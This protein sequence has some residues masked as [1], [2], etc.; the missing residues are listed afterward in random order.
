MDPTPAPR[1]SGKV[2]G[3]LHRPQRYHRRLQRVFYASA[4]VS[5]QFDPNSR[6]FYDRKVRHEALDVRVEVRDRAPRGAV[7]RVRV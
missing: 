6:K 5:I 4:L 3:N 7:I 1:D 2:V